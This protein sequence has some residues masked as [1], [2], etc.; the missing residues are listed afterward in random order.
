[1]A[2]DA[3]NT[4]VGTYDRYVGFNYLTG[5]AAPQTKNSTDPTIGGVI[6]F[7]AYGRLANVHYGFRMTD[8]ATNMTGPPNLLGQF[9]FPAEI[10]ANSAYTATDQTILTVNNAAPLS[11]F[12][13]VLFDR[14]TA[15]DKFGSGV[16]GFNKDVWFVLNKPIPPGD[17]E[18][19][20]ESWLDDNSTAVLI[21]RYNGTLVKGE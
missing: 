7:D 20:E 14:G 5:V 19:G 4:V 21:N 11:S 10:T 2:N 3:S 13:F 9:A 18:I 12:G 16:D 1:M 17:P 15:E 8:F 6:L